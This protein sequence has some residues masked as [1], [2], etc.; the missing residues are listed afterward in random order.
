MGVVGED[1]GEGGAAEE[2]MRWRV[3]METGAG[4]R[5]RRRE[6]LLGVT[7]MAREE[8]G[9]ARV[10]DGGKLF[11]AAAQ[12]EGTRNICSAIIHN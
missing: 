4:R 10:D 1:D 9:E 11:D 12:S 7:G 5:R 3:M 6:E 2:L 8:E